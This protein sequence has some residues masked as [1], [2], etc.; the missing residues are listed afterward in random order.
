MIVFL[1]G[2]QRSGSTFAFNI[3]RE[4]LRA[5][6]RVYQQDGADI[7]SALSRADGAAH[8]LLKAHEA[9]PVCVALT[10][11]GAIRTICTVRRVEDA[12]ASWIETFGFEEAD[13]I[14]SMR[15]WLD[16]YRQIRPFALTI[17]YELIDK[18]PFLAGWKI[19]RYISP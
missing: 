11:Q 10:R 1:A 17:P 19:G 16:L 8:I 14:E 5:R 7:V 9:D 18:H 12:V 15:K 3:A 6:G 4:V 2:M 13:A